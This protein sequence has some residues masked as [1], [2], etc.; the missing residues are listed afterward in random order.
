MVLQ[1][2]G[3]QPLPRKTAVFVS[4]SPRISAQLEIL[5][6]FNTQEY[7]VWWSRG[8]GCLQWLE[9]TKMV[10]SCIS[11]MIWGLDEVL[12][13]FLHELCKRLLERRK[14]TEAQ[15]DLLKQPSDNPLPS[16][17]R[18]KSK[19]TPKGRES[20]MLGRESEERI[21]VPRWGH[22]VGDLLQYSTRWCCILEIT[23]PSWVPLCWMQ[24]QRCGK[25]TQA[26]FEKPCCSFQGKYGFS[27]LSVYS[28]GVNTDYEF[29]TGDLPVKLSKCCCF[30]WVC[31]R[32]FRAL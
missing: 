3:I 9:S 6:G 22:A 11:H 15:R 18:T 7:K 28:T 25:H 10:S 29:V 2:T 13:A 16:D 20:L 31:D 27:F 24:A 17:T 5:P 8:K 19:P 32:N 21:P 1:S 14:Y 26:P 12:T 23:L 30:I 4:L